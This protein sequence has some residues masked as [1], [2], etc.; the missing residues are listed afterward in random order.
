MKS[1]LVLVALSSSAFANTWIVDANGGAGSSF[2][3][4]GAAVVASVP[5]D[6]LVV[7]PGLYAPFTL[8]RGLSLVGGAGVV[9]QGP[10]FVIGVPTTE[11]AS[12]VGFQATELLVDACAGPVVVQEFYGA[13]HATFHASADVRLRD[14]PVFAPP[15]AT[16]TNGYD[17]DGA[18]V[19]VVDSVVRGSDSNAL[20][21]GGGHGVLVTGG[22]FAHV[23][24]T[25]LTGGDGISSNTPFEY[26]SGGGT[27]LV[28][29]G[30]ASVPCA[31]RLVGSALNAG[32]GA[33]NWA[34]T[35]SCEYDGAPG[36][37]AFSYQS[38][39]WHSATTVVAPSFQYGIHCI[40]FPGIPFGGSTHVEATPDDPLLRVDG[41]P[42]Q[43]GLITFRVH[44]PPGAVAGLWLG[45]SLR[46]VATPPTQV[47]S[48]V[49]NDR[50]FV[51]GTISASGVLQRNLV[52]PAY[53]P[54]GFVFGAQAELL[55]PG[56]DTRRTNS[57]P[58][59]VR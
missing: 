11:R 7:R 55:Y 53:L 22:G 54:D 46:V 39:V 27:A 2:T 47:E 17:V 25:S 18:R 6:V 45:R 34:M 56:G 35:S 9:V 13:A 57:A 40:L 30:T 42:T 19:E 36:E 15:S 14:V 59:V 3:D 31:A 23:L 51:L 1:W 58:I 8:D 24:A 21:A 41:T 29:S 44:G 33:I 52:V 12:V 32:N 37:G 48:L 4:V 38:T 49:T 50:F 20:P 26:A 5:G 28:V 16:S 10:V 43:G